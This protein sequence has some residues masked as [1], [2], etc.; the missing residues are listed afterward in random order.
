MV[1]GRQIRSTH[2]RKIANADASVQAE[3][4]SEGRLPRRSLVDSDG[5]APGRIGPRRQDTHSVFIGL[6]V[7][8]QTVEQWFGEGERRHCGANALADGQ[9]GVELPLGPRDHDETIEPLAEVGIFPDPAPEIPRILIREVVDVPALGEV[10]AVQVVVAVAF[11][12]GSHISPV[13]VPS[14]VGVSTP[15]PAV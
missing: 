8:L 13:L 15:L 3:Q 9:G 4:L 5:H 11:E 12:L 10:I 1:K 7:P 6:E 14:I 2:C